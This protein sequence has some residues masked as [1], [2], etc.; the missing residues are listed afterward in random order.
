ML[1]TKIG[2]FLIGDNPSAKL[3]SSDSRNPTDLVAG[4]HPNL[5]LCCRQPFGVWVIA[6]HVEKD[7]RGGLKSPGRPNVLVV[8]NLTLASEKNK[9]TNKQKVKQHYY[10]S[11]V[12]SETSNTGQNV[13]TI[14]RL[15]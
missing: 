13:P 15:T 6:K 12:K 8:D 3:S 5:S 11:N 14:T 7:V 1:L 9:Q 4:A 10:C 2:V